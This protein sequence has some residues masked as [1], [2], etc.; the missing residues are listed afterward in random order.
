MEGGGHGESLTL[1]CSSLLKLRASW[2]CR[3]SS[4]TAGGWGREETQHKRHGMELNT[5]EVRGGGKVEMD[6][7]ADT[8]TE[9]HHDSWLVKGHDL[10]T[11]SIP[12][13]HRSNPVTLWLAKIF[14]DSFRNLLSV[15][16]QPA[17]ERT[18]TKSTP[19][20]LSFTL[21]TAANSPREVWA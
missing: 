6:G 21:S 16:E 12:D 4:A 10:A 5:A 20:V 11:L 9:Y 19:T 18:L 1:S 7:W 8:S 14:L 15:P 17:K 2:S 13:A 3:S